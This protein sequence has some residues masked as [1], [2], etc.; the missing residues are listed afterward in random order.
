[1]AGSRLKLLRNLVL[2]G[3]LHKGHMA[4]PRLAQVGSSKDMRNDAGV[5]R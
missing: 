2:T 3:S 5:I 1:M 4:R